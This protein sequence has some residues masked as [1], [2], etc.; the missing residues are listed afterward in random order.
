MHE[1]TKP[2][3][4]E[5]HRTPTR[6]ISGTKMKRRKKIQPQSCQCLK[7]CLHCSN[8]TIILRYVVVGLF[9][10]LVAHYPVRW[11][12]LSALIHLSSPG[13]PVQFW[14][15]LGFSG[16]QQLCT[17]TNHSHKIISNTVYETENFGKCCGGYLLECTSRIGVKSRSKFVIN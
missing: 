11:T 15:E 12:A 17:M 14:H 9:I 2:H 13:R 5:Y 10:L 4:G 16:K 7:P 1:S 8:T 3:K 6:Q